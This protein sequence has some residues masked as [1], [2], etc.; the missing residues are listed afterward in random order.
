MKS[1]VT[2]IVGL[3]LGALSAPAQTYD[4]SWH[5]IDCGGATFMAGGAFELGGTIGQPDAGTL[6]G[7]VFELAGGFWVG[8]AVDPCTL[9]GDLDS[10]R[11]VDLTDLAGLLGNF[12]VQGGATPAMG[13]V[14]GD[15][16]VDIGDL[17]ALLA[18]FGSICP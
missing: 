14:D 3:L 13:D 2:T 9:R 5:T 18:N 11:D 7:G 1:L 4:L 10:D 12:G 8:G 16:D 6:V 15:Q 17:S